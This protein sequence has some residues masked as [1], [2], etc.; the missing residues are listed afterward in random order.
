MRHSLRSHLYEEIIG[1]LNSRSLGAVLLAAVIGAFTVHAFIGAQPAFTM[2]EIKEPSWRAYL[3][4]PFAAGLAALAGGFFQRASISL[5][6]KARSIRFFPGW[7][8]PLA[9]GIGTWILGIS[10]FASTGRLA[11]FGLGYDDLSDALAHGMVWKLA[12]VL[13]VAKLAATILCY[14]LGGCG[15][16]FSPNLFFGAMCGAVVAGIGSHFLALDQSDQLLLAVGGMSA[17]LGAVVQAPFTGFLIIFEMTHQFAL[18]PGLMLAG[19]V[20]Q[21]IARRFNHVNFYDEVLLQDGHQMEHVIPP[22][23]FRSW[24]GLPISAIA[25]FNPIVIDGLKEETLKQ[26]L[27]NHPYRH[28]P[29]IENGRL[30]GIAARTEIEEAI[31]E[32]RA[33][34]LSPALACRPSD[35]VRESQRALIE[36]TTGTVVLMDKS[37]GVVLAVVTLHDI[38]RAQ[39]SLGEREGDV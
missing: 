24:Q 18:V 34:K 20:S 8:H 36:S 11:V 38:L 21:I 12:A 19:L 23:D 25:N 1:D 14:G 10:V 9:G 31:S 27:T 15:G 32:H 28:F 3:L 7:L 5:R 35:T 26:A 13:L 4:M 6:S 39:I 22:R 29:V 37:D 30:L 17:C 16:I 33:V 2:P